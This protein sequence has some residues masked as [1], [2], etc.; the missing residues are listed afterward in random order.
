MCADLSPMCTSLFLSNAA[1]CYFSLPSTLRRVVVMALAF[2]F[3]LFVE[4][5]LFAFH[6]NLEFSCL[7][8]FFFPPGF[9]TMAFL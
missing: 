5:T 6:S 7:R 1:G 2:H 9:T 4:L 8:L 3:V